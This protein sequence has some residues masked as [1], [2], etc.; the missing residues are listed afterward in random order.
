VEVNALIY[1]IEVEYGSADFDPVFHK[2]LKFRY[3]KNATIASWDVV[4]WWKW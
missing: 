1:N 3:A 2:D 4:K